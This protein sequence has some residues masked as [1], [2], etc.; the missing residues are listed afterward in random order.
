LREIS[1]AE[2][3]DKWLRENIIRVKGYEYQKSHILQ[4]GPYALRNKCVLDEALDILA[5]QKKIVI[6]YS[7]GQKIIYIGDAITPCELANEANIPI[8]ER[9]MFMVC[10]D[11][12]LNKYRNEEQTKIWNITTKN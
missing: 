11:H 10:W 7:I 9:G 12:K 6:D 3:L 2:K 5:E 1:P 8:M 4:Y